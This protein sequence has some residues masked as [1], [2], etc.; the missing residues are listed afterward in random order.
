MNIISSLHFIFE[1]S[2]VDGHMGCFQFLPIINKVLINIGGSLWVYK[3]S[4][5]GVNMYE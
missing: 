3:L 4:F 2:L 5:F 1:F